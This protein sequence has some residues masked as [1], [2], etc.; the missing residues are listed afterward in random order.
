MTFLVE[1]IGVLGCL[2]FEMIIYDKL[3]VNNFIE[4]H[5]H[6]DALLGKL[7][8]LIIF[9]YSII[10]YFNYYFLQRITFHQ[11]FVKLDLFQNLEFYKMI[12]QLKYLFLF[13]VFL[14][15]RHFH[16]Y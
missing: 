4:A 16:Y 13:Q 2:N 7:H 14:L 1:P 5:K 9:K 6:V 3:E 8:A 12:R 11:Y 10:D 15:I